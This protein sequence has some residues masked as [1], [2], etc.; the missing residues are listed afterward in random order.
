[1]A[2]GTGQNDSTEKLSEEI[3]R[4]RDVVSRDLRGLRYELDFPRKVRQSFRRETILW[5]TAA[6]AVGIILATIP[7]RT[8]KIYVDAKGG[9]KKKQNRL[10]EAGF[11]LGAL[12]IAASL[13][14]PV[15]VDLVRTRL[16]GSGA[17][18]PPPPK[19]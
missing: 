6:V 7:A 11:V 9:G 5:I 13:A 15:I 12:K 4:S 3:A 2:E 10:L 1:M 17:K 19:W 16:F 8:K 18:T 14:R